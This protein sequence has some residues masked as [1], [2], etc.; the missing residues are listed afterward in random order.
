MT[1][2]IDKSI[3]I[4]IGSGKKEVIEFA[5]VECPFCRRAE[6]FFKDADVTRYVFLYPLDSIHPH[7]TAWS[8]HILCSDDPA[9]EFEKVMHDQVKEFK[10][11]E[12]GRQALMRHVAQGDKAGVSSVPSFR[13]NGETVNGADPKIMDMIK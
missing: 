9:E 12:K 3:A 13:I 11:C 1:E 4:K 7:A 6:N 2:N 10:D 5:D 8:I